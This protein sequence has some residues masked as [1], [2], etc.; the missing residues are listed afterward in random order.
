MNQ[1]RE[2]DPVHRGAVADVLLEEDDLKIGMIMREALDQV[3]LGADGPLRPGLGLL[4]EMVLMMNSVDPIRSGQA[5]TSCLHSGCTST[6][7]PK[8][9]AR[10]SSTAC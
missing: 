10:T 2:V 5:T 9:R 4:G 1:V 7:T 8:S 3:E 6:L